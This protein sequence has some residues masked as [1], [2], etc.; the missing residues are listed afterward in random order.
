MKIMKSKDT[1]RLKAMTEPQKYIKGESD[2]AE[3]LAHCSGKGEAYDRGYAAQSEREQKESNL[4]IGE[5]HD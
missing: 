1:R 3:G 5:Q 2:C 4:S